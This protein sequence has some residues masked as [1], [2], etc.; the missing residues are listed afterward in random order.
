MCSM[1][2]TTLTSG[3]AAKF[4]K[5]KAVDAV[6]RRA[7]KP[8]KKKMTGKKGSKKKRDSDDSDDSDEEEEVE[9]LCTERAAHNS[10]RC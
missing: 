8:I 9:G 7:P 5:P 2:L 6:V 1:T 4:L 3:N 10:L